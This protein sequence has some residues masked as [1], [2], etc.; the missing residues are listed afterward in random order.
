MREQSTRID[1]LSSEL[2]V[3]VAMGASGWI[4]RACTGRF[5]S[6]ARTACDCMCMQAERV[7]C[8]AASDAARR[9]KDEVTQLTE[10]LDT[11]EGELRALLAAVEQQKAN[12][13]VKM[14]QLASLL[15]DLG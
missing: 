5:P 11:S 2:Q 1:V 12:S 8:K 4:R 15:S 9:A 7:A 13:A 14:R 3:C 6:T 10:R